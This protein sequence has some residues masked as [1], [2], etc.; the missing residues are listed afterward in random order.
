MAERCRCACCL[1]SVNC[2][3]NRLSELRV[4]PAQRR[5]LDSPRP[6]LFCICVPT[7][8]PLQDHNQVL[9]ILRCVVPCS[10]SALILVRVTCRVVGHNGEAWF[11]KRLESRLPCAF[12][13]SEH[14]ASAPSD[15]Q[16]QLT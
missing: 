4:R 2:S 5:C 3:A 9:A 1:F 8:P 10:H 6:L 7:D 15:L 13:A 12:N 14:P 16:K 11:V